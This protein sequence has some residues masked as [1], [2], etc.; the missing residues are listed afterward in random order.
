MPFDTSNFDTSNHFGVCVDV[1]RGLILVNEWH[2]VTTRDEALVLAAWIR[3][4]ADPEG[5]EFERVVKEIMK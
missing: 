3:V 4:L 1:V 2:R 5:K